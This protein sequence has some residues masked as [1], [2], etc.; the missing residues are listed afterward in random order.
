MRRYYIDNIRW[1]TV[2]LVVLYHVI[3]MFNGIIGEGV[4]GAFNKVQYQDALQYILYPWFMVILFVVSGISARCFLEKHTIKE[5][6][7][8]KTRRLLVP[9][10]IGLFVFWWILG[11]YSMSISGAFEVMPNSMPPVILYIIM[12]ISGTGVLWYIQVLWVFSMILALFRK[13][14]KGKLFALTGKMNFAMVL[15]LMFPLWVAAQFLNTPV[16]VVYRFGIYGLS[17]FIG[18]FI[19]AHEEIIERISK[20]WHL[21]SVLAICLGAVYVFAYW[22]ENFAQEPILNSPLTIVYCWITVLAV[23]ANMKKWG[24]KTNAFLQYMSRKSF[25]LYVFHYLPLSICAFYMDKYLK[26]PAVMVYIIVGAAAFA[27]GYLLYE[28]ISRIPFVSWCVLGIT[29]NERRKNK[30]NKGGKYV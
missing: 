27:G 23:F 5:F 29:A 20:Y 15:A 24:D 7:A 16:I 25:G 18:Y 12:S 11:Y 9:S 4:I 17:F 8:S 2:I 6:I 10:T 3:Y 30:I 14:E 1:I 28:I 26:L 19:F 13:F 21:L 22:G